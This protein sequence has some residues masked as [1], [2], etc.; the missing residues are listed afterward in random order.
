LLE[1]VPGLLTIDDGATLATVVSELED[2]GY[3]V[4]HKVINS[5]LL[6]PQHRCRLYFVCLRRDGGKEKVVHWIPEAID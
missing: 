6:V 4:Q 1:N 5:S 3:D 2:A